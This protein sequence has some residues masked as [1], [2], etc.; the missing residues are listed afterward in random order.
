MDPENLVINASNPYTDVESILLY[1]RTTILR[2][3]G[4][5]VLLALGGLS[6]TV[7]DKYERLLTDEN[8]CRKFIASVMAFI[9]KYEFDGLDIEV[10]F[11]VK[12]IRFIIIC[13]VIFFNFLNYFNI[14]Y[15]IRFVWNMIVD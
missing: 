2:E 1:K 6:D 11:R 3:N 5:K 4:I 10:S 12:I 7:G 8:N 15:S 9:Y 14:F 13:S